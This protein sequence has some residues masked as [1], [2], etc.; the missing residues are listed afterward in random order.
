ML[1][2][3]MSSGPLVTTRIT[4]KSEFALTNEEPSHEQNGET[5]LADHYLATEKLFQQAHS[6]LGS[7]DIECQRLIRTRRWT[8]IDGENFIFIT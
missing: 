3:S 8:R 5:L 7:K 6:L 1:V 4:N 2:R